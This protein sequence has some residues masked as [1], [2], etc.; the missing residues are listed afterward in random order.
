MP[1]SDRRARLASEEFRGKYTPPE[2]QMLQD[3]SEDLAAVPN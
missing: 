2:Q 3:L 1:E